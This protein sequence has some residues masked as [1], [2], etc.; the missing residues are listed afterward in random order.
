MIRQTRIKLVTAF[1]G[2]FNEA[3]MIQ[4][5]LTENGIKATLENGFMASIA[6]W[7]VSPGG[8]SPV[9]VSVNDTDLEA[10]LKL[11]EEFNNSEEVPAQPDDLV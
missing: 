1:S 2:G 7:V 3:K 8:F 10:A 11:I 9:N 6:P 5:I 4:T